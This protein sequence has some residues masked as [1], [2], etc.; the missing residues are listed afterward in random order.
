MAITSESLNPTDTPKRVTAE[1][2]AH[3]VCCGKDVEP[4]DIVDIP[5]TEFD[6]LKAAHKAK[7]HVEPKPEADEQ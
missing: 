6:T 7:V 5:Q 3:T 1:I 2:T 4:G